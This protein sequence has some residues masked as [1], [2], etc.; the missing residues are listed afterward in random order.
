MFL[1]LLTP[2]QQRLFLQAS[3]S[4]LDADGDLANVEAALM[5]AARLECA[6]D[7]LPERLPREQLVAWARDLLDSTPAR[8]AFLLELAGAMVVDG[9]SA[10]PELEMLRAL[11]D[12]TGGD[13]ALL[14][15]FVDF[16]R[17]AADV[18]ADGH[19][20]LAIEAGVL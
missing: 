5:D 1:S 14:A 15:E 19:R 10:P 16:A 7:D 12:A 8:N 17:R 20:L 4:M 6:V 11:G 9:E 18:L 13:E 3:R 2:D